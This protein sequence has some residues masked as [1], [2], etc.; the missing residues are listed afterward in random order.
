MRTNLLAR[1]MT[2]VHDLPV[3]ELYVYSPY[4]CV[5]GAS[6]GNSHLCIVVF[7]TRIKMSRKPHPSQRGR[8]WSCCNHR[9]VATCCDQ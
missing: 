3:S 1:H 5:R 7:V 6:S 9:V 8:V 4:A 2:L